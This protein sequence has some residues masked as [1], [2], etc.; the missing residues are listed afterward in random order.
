MS[1]S[2]NDAI[3]EEGNKSLEINIAH[4]NYE[5]VR[6]TADMLELNENW[7]VI[8]IALDIFYKMLRGHKLSE[9]KLSS[10]IISSENMEH[11]IVI[12]DFEQL[13]VDAKMLE[14]NMFK[15]VNN[16]DG[17]NNNEEES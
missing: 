11:S 14:M 13:K 15:N 17:E 1:F 12:V 7:P 10:I 2:F 4:E 5:I 3:D 16:D 8:P 9:E 6:D